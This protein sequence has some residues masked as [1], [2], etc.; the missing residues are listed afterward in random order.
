MGFRAW[1]LVCTAGLGCAP[2][3]A[4]GP[5][6][7]AEEAS[8]ASS[9]VTTERRQNGAVLVFIDEGGRRVADLT[10]TEG[11]AIIDRQPSFSPDGRRLVFASNR[12]RRGPEKTSLWIAE[13]VPGGKLTRVTDTRAVDRDPVWTPDGKAIIFASDRGGSFDLYRLALHDEGGH[14]RA[15]GAAVQLTSTEAQALAPAVSPDG[16]RIAFM[17]VDGEGRSSLWLGSAQR[18]SQPEQLTRGPADATPTF[19]PDGTTIYF[20]AQAPGRSDADIYSVDVRGHH[21]RVVIAEPDADQSGPRM[22]ADGRTLFATAVYRSQVNGKPIL[23]S[24]VSAAMDAS[25]RW[26]ALHDPAFVESRVG[27]AL[28]PGV[29]GVALQRNPEYGPALRRALERALRDAAAEEAQ[30]EP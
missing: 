17:E 15:A 29:D 8:R 19:G 27:V 6:K 25:P 9:I 2:L 5:A 14:V 12:G 28:A 10:T 21:K 11:Q 22:S 1:I 16:T 3:P 30:G 26:R 18:R 24:V 20:A 7:R 23:A 4:G 13:A